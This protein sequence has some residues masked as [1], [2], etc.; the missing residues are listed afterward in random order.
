[1]HSYNYLCYPH[2]LPHHLCLF[3]SVAGYESLLVAFELLVAAC[4]I[5]FP[6]Q[7]LNLDPLHWEH[8]VLAT[9]P[10]GARVKDL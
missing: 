4:G 2:A 1:M 10:P 3:F 9:G 6:D 7:G 5:Q 8:G